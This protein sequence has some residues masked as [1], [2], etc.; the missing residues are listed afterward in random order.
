MNPSN[1]PFPD[2]ILSEKT[3]QFTESCVVEDFF[4]ENLQ[5]YHSHCL[6]ILRNICNEGSLATFRVWISGVESRDYK[7]KV[8][9]NPP[10][11]DET[12]AGWSNRIFGYLKFG[13]IINNVEK[14]DSDLNA[15][16]LET[17]Q[18]ISDNKIPSGGY[19]MAFFIGNYDQTPLGIHKDLQGGRTIHFHLG[20]G[21]K[22]IY[23][24]DD[25]TIEQY[26]H[27]LPNE[28]DFDLL[29]PQANHFTFKE[30]DLFF[31]PENIWHVGRSDGLS[32]ALSCWFNYFNRNQLL[33]DLFKYTRERLLINNE[34]TMSS[35]SN[36]EDIYNSE[37]PVFQFNLFPRHKEAIE[38]FFTEL[39][40]A[41]RVE[42]LSNGGFITPPKK[43]STATTIKLKS[44]IKLFQPFLIFQKEIDSSKTSLFV[45]G[46]Q[47]IIPNHLKLPNVISDINSGKTFEVKVLVEPLL[48][49]WS[50]DLALYVV[51][52]LIA[53]QGIVV[54]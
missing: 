21:K 31:M 6:N 20:P 1:P 9:D 40:D 47:I 16:V 14:Y 52:Q 3:V 33:D 36:E 7:Q 43:L 32:M 34:K 26:A 51:N 53:N 48:D 4:V 46:R 19:D 45:R 29:V 11:L 41:Y 28:V 50:E 13:M 30:G 15:K 2:P 22:T 23:Q 39:Y 17:I 10:E 54:I 5:F 18:I 24:W 37:R 49:V 35:F 27:N 12:F 42:L 38:A 25:R 44:H 8:T